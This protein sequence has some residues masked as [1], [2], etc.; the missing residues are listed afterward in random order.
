MRP[1]RQ[2]LCALVLLGCGSSTSAS[3][4]K[5]GDSTPMRETQ[6]LPTSSTPEPVPTATAT[7]AP[8]PP[9]PVTK[10]TASAV[11]SASSS[12]KTS[13]GKLTKDECTKIVKKFA[14]NVA[15]DKNA[16]LK[17]GFEQI[18]MFQTMVDEC[19]ANSTRTQ[20]DCVM[21]TKTMAQWMGCMK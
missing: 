9:V 21:A 1:S 11:P 20:Y 6:S 4:P 14:E 18:P 5:S 3:P 12:A 19:V 15:M 2:V 13:T 16:E 17:A 10:T 7:V 8:I